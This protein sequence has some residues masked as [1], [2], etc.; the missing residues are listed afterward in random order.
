MQSKVNRERIKVLRLGK[1]WTQQKLA[2]IA[3]ISLRSIQ[4]IERDGIAS[5]QSRGAIAD[6]FGIEP[7]ELEL[8]SENAESPIS[9]IL[10]TMGLFLYSSFYACL[11]L[12]DLRLDQLPLWS[13]PILPSISLLIFGFILQARLST[14]SRRLL[15]V[16]ACLFLAMLLT[17]P[18]PTIQV[19][20]ALVLW[21]IFEFCAFSAEFIGARLSSF[22]AFR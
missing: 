14:S 19:A 20:L 17:P 13:I 6:A 1:S 15:V 22:S 11:S 21:V 7:V 2:E 9:V 4:R 16:A 8:E 3:G 10:L 18:D 12:L 5:L